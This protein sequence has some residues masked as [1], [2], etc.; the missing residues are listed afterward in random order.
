MTGLFFL[1]LMGAFAILG[2]LSMSITTSPRPAA[3]VSMGASILAA[4]AGMAG[5][6]LLMSS[7]G[8]GRLAA[9]AWPPL[10][11]FVLSADGLSLLFILLISLVWLLISLFSWSYLTRLEGRY[12]LRAFGALYNL[13]FLA[14]MLT[15]LAGDLITFLAAWEVVT[16]TSYLLIVFEHQSAENTRAGSFMLVFSEIGALLLIAAF[17]LLGNYTGHFDFAGIRAAIG[18]VPPAVKNTVFI[19]TLL[20]FGVKIGLV[21]LQGWFAPAYGAAPAN[22]GAVLSAATLT[23]GIYG[24]ARVGLDLLGPSPLWWGLALLV[25]GALT[26]IT[27]MLYGLMEHD[28]KRMLSLSSVENT[29]WI[30][31]GLGAA[32]VYR[33]SGLPVLAALAAITALYQ[34]VNNA[35]YKSLLFMGA[36]AVEYATGC[37]DMDQL[38]G[39]SRVMPYTA[40][41]FIA[42]SL[43]AAGLPPFNGFVSE[44]L[45]LETL[46]LS[47][48]L[49]PVLPKVVMALAGLTLALTAA[50]AITCFVKACGTAFLGRARSDG[51]RKAAEVPGSMKL[52]MGGATVLSLLL[53]VLPTLVIPRL[54]AAAARLAGAGAA[55]QMIPA[56]FTHPGRFSTL[57]LLGGTFLRGILPAPGAVVVPTDPGFSSISPTYLLFALP[58][59]MLLGAGVVRLLGGKT[60]VARGEVWAGGEERFTPAQQYTGTAYSNPVL[61]L[62]RAFYR[63]R[64]EVER[65]YHGANGFRAATGY[66]R[67]IEPLAERY[68]YRPAASAVYRGARLLAWIQSGRLNQYV[69]YILLLL[70]AVM[71]YAVR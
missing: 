30:L 26:A 38:G 3:A 2:L 51:A 31:A 21:P 1:Y 17:A 63:P 19:L 52:A 71:V 12:N 57:A 18:S 14:L 11:T 42:G 36:G 23:L 24:L 34:T 43:A 67:R 50:L 8:A 40:L 15:T 27:G 53:G 54:N 39:L 56:V 44:W 20:G 48:H 47:F 60:A 70:A 29:G 13:L 9:L 22:V 28:L 62:F 7:G 58:L 10:G 69:G 5:A 6:A 35:V 66:E 37:Q 25:L 46:L 41:F 59:A 49:G 61:V 45:T 64:V 65:H 4:L 68:L 33:A 16:V 32:G 55:A